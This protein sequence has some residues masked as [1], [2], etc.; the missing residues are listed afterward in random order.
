MVMSLLVLTLPLFFPV[1]DGYLL[2]TSNASSEPAFSSNFENVLFE[3]DFEHGSLEGW[4]FMD[5]GAYSIVEENGN[6]VLKGNG[7]KFTRTGESNW[8]VISLEVSVKILR[9]NVQISFRYDPKLWLE[10]RYALGMQG[11]KLDLKKAW[12]G[13]WTTLAEANLPLETRTWYRVKIVVNGPDICVYLNGNL[14]I[15]ASEESLILHG[16]ISLEA[17]EAYFDDVKVTGSISTTGSNYA[18]TGAPVYV[19]DGYAASNLFSS[20]L[21]APWDVAFGPNGDLFVAE[22]TGCRVSRVTANGSVSTYVEIPKSF[23]GNAQSIAFSSS[24][25]LYMIGGG[26]ILKF[27]PNQTVTAFAI[28]NQP[29]YTELSGGL[30]QLAI[31]PSGDIFVIEREAGE[32]SRITPSGVIATFASGLSLPSDL[33]FGPS[34]DLFVFEAGSGEI[35]RITPDGKITIFASGFARTESFMAFDLQGDL[36]VNQGWPLYRITP[37][38]T[39]IPLGHIHDLT[40]ACFRDMTFDSSGNLYVADGTGS[41]ILRILPNNT[42]SV[43][44]HGFMSSGLAVGPSGD[45]FAIDTAYM[46]GTPPSVGILKVSLNGTS[47]TFATVSGMAMDIGFDASGSLYVTIFDEGKILK[48]NPKGE[49]STFVTGLQ[50]P[51]SLSFGPSG[52]LIVFENYTGHILKIAPDLEVSTFAK[53][54]KIAEPWSIRFGPDLAVDS[55]GTVYVG[56]HGENNTIYKIFPNGTVTTFATGIS[57]AGIW[58]C[59]DMTVSPR[60]DIF[61]TEAAPGKLYRVTQYKSALFATGLV[62]DPH[63][64]TCNP[65]GELFIARG[66]SIVKIS[67]LIYVYRSFVSGKRVGVGSSQA[68]G[69]QAVWGHNGSAVSNGVVCVNGS[70]YATNSTG[71]IRLEVSSP[72]VGKQT[73]AVTGVSSGGISSYLQTAPNPTIIWDRVAITLEVEDTRI[74]VGRNATITWKGAYEYDGSPFTGTITLNDTSTKGVLGA[75]HYTVQSISDDTYGITVFESNTVSVAIDRCYKTT[76]TAS[77]T[78]VQVTT[79]T[80]A[81]TSTTATIKTTTATQTGPSPIAPELLGII[82]IV[83]LFAVIVGILVRRSLALQKRQPSIDR[84]SHAAL[85]RFRARCASRASRRTARGISELTILLPS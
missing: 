50:G 26:G 17:E 77:T 73:W 38:G 2:F 72:L 6:H 39:V 51:S 53:G 54:F 60:G 11:G 59:G 41:R 49:V 85:H 67:P 47:T 10:G 19:P 33:E 37:N 20:A 70:S 63:S 48:I 80:G 84:S 13:E 57:D 23:R 71:W 69:L 64:I 79:T 32:I 34:G 22:Y 68:V 61:A 81:T 83:G 82:A 65:S 16:G 28:C 74:E 24:G 27:F 29:P 52:D 1:T 18:G 42:F 66:G 62:N 55:L 9:G 43:L 58:D 30:G 78:K 31:V 44:V 36:Y 12:Q 21:V 56:I 8:I 15:H 5:G 14:K 3:D 40:P 7:W 35:S 25:D 46:R 4:E 45:I 76:P 75:Y